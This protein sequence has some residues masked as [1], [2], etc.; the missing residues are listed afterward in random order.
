[1]LHHVDRELCQYRR[2]GHD[3]AVCAAQYVPLDL[4]FR[5]C[6]LPDY[7]RAHVEAALLDAFSDRVL[8]SGQSGFF[9]PDNLTFGGG[10]YVSKLLAAAQSVTGVESV[11]LIRLQR[12][13]QGP[14]GEI[15]A[16]I[17]PIK[18]FEIARLDNEPSFPEHGQISFDLRGGR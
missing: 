15:A 5:I 17:L 12:L 14:N 9:N 10:I 16:G 13:Y 18:A 6:V 8:P 2:V 4:A 3:V 7:L 1:L 11:C